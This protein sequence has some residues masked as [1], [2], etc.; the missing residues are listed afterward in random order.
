M[1]I[2][3]VIKTG[4]PVAVYKVLKERYKSNTVP[5]FFEFVEKLSDPRGRGFTSFLESNLQTPIGI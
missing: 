4:D 5:V 3:E 1:L 2:N